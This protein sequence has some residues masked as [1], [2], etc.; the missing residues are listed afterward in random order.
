[1]QHV[2]ASS[3]N[4]PITKV[5]TVAAIGTQ[6]EVAWRRIVQ[7]AGSKTKKIIDGIQIRQTATL[8]YHMFHISQPNPSVIHAELSSFTCDASEPNGHCSITFDSPHNPKIQGQFNISKLTS[9]Y[10]TELYLFISQMDPKIRS[11][12]EL[13]LIHISEPTRPY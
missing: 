2:D 3:H 13:S 12:F 11:L 6:R 4:S 8:P 9:V 1:M 7:E 10:M 5:K